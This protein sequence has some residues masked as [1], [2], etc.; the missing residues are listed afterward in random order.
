MHRASGTRTVPGAA[1][2]AFPA[3][4]QAR[5]DTVPESNLS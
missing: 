5:G 1:Y 2:A 4:S 3:T